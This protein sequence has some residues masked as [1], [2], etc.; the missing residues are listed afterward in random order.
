VVSR[1]SRRPRTRWLAE[2]GRGIARVLLVPVAASGACLGVGQAA[3]ILGAGAW[4]VALLHLGVLM[5]VAAPF[6]GLLW[7][8]PVLWRSDPAGAGFA[9]G[10]LGV[11]LVGVL[12]ALAGR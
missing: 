9:I 5:L 11:S 7:L 4:A 6:L 10:T 2:V 8:V 3:V 12:L 1:S